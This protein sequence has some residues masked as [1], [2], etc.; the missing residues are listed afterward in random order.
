MKAS[1][2]PQRIGSVLL[3]V[4]LGEPGCPEG[5]FAATGLVDGD[6]DERQWETSA[7]ANAYGIF[8]LAAGKRDDRSGFGHAVSGKRHD[9]DFFRFLGQSLRQS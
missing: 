7:T 5:Q 9:A 8:R 2:V 3:R 6:L 4:A 1:A